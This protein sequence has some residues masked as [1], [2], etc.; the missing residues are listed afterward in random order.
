MSMLI[1]IMQ[2]SIKFLKNK[3]Y[4]IQFKQKNTRKFLLKWNIWMLKMF[5]A[6]GVAVDIAIRE[7]N[8]V[9]TFHVPIAP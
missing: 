5:G 7:R 6:F 4:I 9:R 3:K 1:L 8:R 2:L